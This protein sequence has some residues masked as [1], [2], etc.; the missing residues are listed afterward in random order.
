[1][2]LKKLECPSCGGDI[3][4]D[5]NSR[6]LFCPYCGANIVSTYENEI[7]YHTIDEAKIREAELR[8][9]T[10]L[11]QLELELKRRETE[12][13]L[14][15]Q[16]RKH[17]FRTQIASFASAGI[18][19]LIGVYL[20]LKYP[21]WAD[22]G[23]R[24][25]LGL[26]L[27]SMGIATAIITVSLRFRKIENIAEQNRIKMQQPSININHVFIP[28][29]FDPYN[30]DFETVELALRGFGFKD[31][32]HVNLKDLGFI[33]R[34]R[35]G[36]VKEVVINGESMDNEV[37]YNARDLVIVRYHGYKKK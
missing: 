7:V 2:N 4:M 25:L 27:I 24:F 31:V 22:D 29:S 34:G 5:E 6:I 9:A 36:L 15:E 19:F 33:N 30:K 28:E 12:R 26:L 21:A 18:M 16:E 10:E 32:R 37:V 8:H 17:R 23:M 35:D 1:M 20:M 13:L 3:S 14:K 11:K